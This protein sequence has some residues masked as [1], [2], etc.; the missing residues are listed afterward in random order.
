MILEIARIYSFGMV[1]GLM[2]FIAVYF[3]PAGI[4]YRQWLASKERELTGK[5]VNVTQKKILTIVTITFV[6][7]WPIPVFYALKFVINYLRK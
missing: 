6:M 3:G 7:L 2:L 4:A 1:A 5:G